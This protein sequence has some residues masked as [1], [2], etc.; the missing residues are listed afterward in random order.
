MAGVGTSFLFEAE[1]HCTG[2]MVLCIS[3]PLLMDP[4]LLLAVVTHA[5]NTGVHRSVRFSFPWA[6]SGNGIS[7]SRDRLLAWPRLS[8]A[9]PILVSACVQAVL[10]SWGFLLLPPQ[11]CLRGVLSAANAPPLSASNC[12]VGDL[13]LAVPI[14][15]PQL[16][17]TLLSLCGHT[18]SLPVQLP[19]PGT[20]QEALRL[21][22]SCCPCLPHCGSPPL[23]LRILRTN[24]HLFPP[25]V[26]SWVGASDPGP[27]IPGPEKAS[28]Q[29]W[30]GLGFP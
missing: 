3:V 22:D 14:S 26:L 6:Q 8:P 18:C 23:H 24:V 15:S 2:W 5:V 28:T 25:E 29:G 13:Q 30:G 27:R 12:S 17:H 10:S 20:P 9:H 7:G 1:E 16:M 11:L 21:P 4:W 19:R